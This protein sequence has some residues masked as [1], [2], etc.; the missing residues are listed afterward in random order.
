MSKEPKEQVGIITAIWQH[1]VKSMGGLKLEQAVL[2]NDGLLG[3]RCYALM[4]ESGR[5]VASAKLPEK[6]GELLKLRAS[7]V[8]QPKKGEQLPVAR[9]TSTEGLD[10]L[11]TDGNV[12]DLLSAFLGRPVTL[13]SSRP[14]VVS[15]E[16]LD[17]LDPA[18]SILDIGDLMLKNKFADYGDVH[19]LT[20]STLNKLTECSPSVQFDE[21]RFRP[22]LV[23]DTVSGA[24]EFVE[25]AWVGKTL[26]IG[27]SVRL[28]ITDPT[29]RCSVPTLSNGALPR[30]PHVLSTIVEHNMLEVPLLD[31]KVLPCAGVYGFVIQGGIVHKGDPVWIES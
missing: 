8:E 5:K 10:V 19:L 11:S 27:D 6:W 28:K 3:D 24:S 7:F 1:P 20:H 29:P 14:D 23:V 26:V 31:N 4:D 2:T 16:R 18:G 9:I 25:N 13:T 21:R 15:L 30:D 17:P 22:N 12:D